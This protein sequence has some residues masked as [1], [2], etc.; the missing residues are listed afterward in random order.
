MGGVLKYLSFR[1]R[2]NR[3]RYWLMVL[4]I[5][6]LM[7]VSAIVAVMLTSV[8]LLAVI[9][10][11]FCV[12]V[13]VAAFA[14]GVRR[15]HDRNKSAWWLLLFYVVPVT[16][17]LPFRVMPDGSPD[18]VQAAAALLAVLGL[19]FSIWGLVELGFLKGTAGPN[20][21]GEDPLGPPLEPAVA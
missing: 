3:Q 19:P 15:L 12:A 20:R 5:G 9:A 2:S 1:G 11:P 13:V 8:P 14:N 6:G 18:D 4:S 7:F 16:L 10:I 21:F 17:G